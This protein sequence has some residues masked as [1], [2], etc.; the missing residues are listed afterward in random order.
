MKRT[1][2]FLL[3]A[4]SF[5]AIGQNSERN[6]VQRNSYV[7]IITNGKNY[8]FL[9]KALKA[10]GSVYLYDKWNNYG[11][12]ETKDDRK[13]VIRNINYNIDSQVFESLFA[14]DSTQI[15]DFDNINS[16]TLNNKKFQLFEFNNE[17][18]MFEYIYESDK[19]Y[20]LKHYRINVFTASNNPMV[21]RPRDVYTKRV[22]YYIKKGNNYKEIKL[23]KKNI[24][25]MLEA[26]GV[27]SNTTKKFVK[28]NK[29]SFA[30]EFD[31]Q[32]ILKFLLKRKI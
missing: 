18:K 22:S 7:Q 26:V 10:K 25:K 20:L 27:N 19:F 28:E 14:K 6:P 8:T 23:N 21:N 17:K 32:M 4:S 11:V 30:K 24:L 13:A 16:I 15:F 5:M 1:L 31:V 29:L 12:I 3:C 2:V 9:P